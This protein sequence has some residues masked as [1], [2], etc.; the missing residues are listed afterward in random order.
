MNN[1]VFTLPLN[2]TNFM[3]LDFTK[4]QLAIVYLFEI[5]SNLIKIYL[6]HIF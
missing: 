6:F 3:S 4:L 1:Q 5:N 2:R